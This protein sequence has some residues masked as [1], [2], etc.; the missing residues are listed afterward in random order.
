MATLAYRLGTMRAGNDVSETGRRAGDPTGGQLSWLQRARASFHKRGA[1]RRLAAAAI[2]I[3]LALVPIAQRL[4]PIAGPPLYDGVVVT[5]PYRWL[6]PPP[7][8][9]GGAQGASGSESIQGENPVLAIATP[10]EPPQA[11]IFAP[12]G[13]LVLPPNTTSLRLSITPIQPSDAPAGGSID[14]NEYSIDVVNQAGA[15][16]TILEDG[17]V[18]VV[19]RGPQ[20]VSGATIERFSGGA[21]QPLQTDAAGLPDTYL[22]V[23]TEFGLFAL[24][25]PATATPPVVGPAPAPTSSREPPSSA[26][27]G[28]TAGAARPSSGSGQSNG[29]NLTLLVAATCLVVICTGLALEVRWY[30]RNR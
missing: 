22:A 9:L 30:R 20:G 7:G 16:V 27:E 4:N 26:L 6:V 29:G 17:E 19:L 2:A 21:W 12:P 1:P 8:G 24:V 10:E 18:T 11:Q 13:S 25:A 14:G 5:Q 15:P 28:A 23:V 3:G